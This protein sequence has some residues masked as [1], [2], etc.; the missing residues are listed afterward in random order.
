MGN[1]LNK[2]DNEIREIVQTELQSAPGSFE[3]VSHT[4]FYSSI[5]FSRYLSDN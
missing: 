5:Q 2:M 1:V 3:Y 4:F